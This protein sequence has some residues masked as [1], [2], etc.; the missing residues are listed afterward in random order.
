MGVLFVDAYSLLH[1]AVGI[2]CYFWGM[3]L[4]MFIF[5]HIIFELV[6]NTPKGMKFINT[7]FK[8]IW[9]GGKDYADSNKNRYGDVFFG[10]IGWL[11]AKYV[12]PN[13]Y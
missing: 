2:V 12:N 8:G 5:L 10:V 11:I 4:P 3:S 9:P 6:E 13:L 1:F 7:N